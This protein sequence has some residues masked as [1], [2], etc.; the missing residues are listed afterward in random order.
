MTKFSPLKSSRNLDTV[1][2]RTCTYVRRREIKRREEEVR[3]TTNRGEIRRPLYIS[4]ARFLV[5]RIVT[6]PGLIPWERE[7]KLSSP[8]R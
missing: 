7:T 3:M 2:S 8:A 5:P 4:P 6:D 1:E